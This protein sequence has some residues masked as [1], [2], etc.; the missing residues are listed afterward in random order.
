MAAILPRFTYNSINVDITV[1][2][3]EE[4]DWKR[5]SFR[6]KKYSLSGVEQT[7]Y[8]YNEFTKAIKITF[9]SSTLRDSLF[10]MWDDWACEGKEITYYPDY[11]NT[12]G[13]SYTVTIVGDTFEA[14][15]VN[16]GVDYWNID[17]VVRRVVT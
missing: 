16:K 12:P 3:K 8:E 15:R 10:D 1:P 2:L 14:K 17:F 6:D 5:K 13:T 9:V 7:A 11:S 4:N